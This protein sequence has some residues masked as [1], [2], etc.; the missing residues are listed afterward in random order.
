MVEPEKTDNAL[1]SRSAVFIITSAGLAAF[2][3]AFTRNLRRASKEAAKLAELH[4]ATTA[5]TVRIHDSNRLMSFILKLH[6]MYSGTFKLKA[7][8]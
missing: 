3:F 1:T 7:H 4:K 2:A 5:E 8:N 6:V